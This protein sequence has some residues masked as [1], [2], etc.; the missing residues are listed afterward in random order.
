MSPTCLLSSFPPCA[1]MLR[2]VPPFFIRT[3]SVNEFRLQ[4]DNFSLSDGGTTNYLS[5]DFSIGGHIWSQLY[6]PA[7][8]FNDLP[9][10]DEERSLELPSI[11]VPRTE[12][13]LWLSYRLA[14][15]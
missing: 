13:C 2:S 12:R 1:N 6:H 4:S 11:A 3:F 14:S 10:D 15:V 7:D 8:F 5:E 9:I